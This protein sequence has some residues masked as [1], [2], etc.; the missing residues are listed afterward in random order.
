MPQW[1][2]LDKKLSILIV[3]VFFSSCYYSNDTL[4]TD[5]ES[6]ISTKQVY[7]EEYLKE[8]ESKK[9]FSKDV[10]IDRKEDIG[11]EIVFIEASY[12]RELRTEPAEIEIYWFGGVAPFY[13]PQIIGL[14][15]EAFQK[16]LNEN[17]VHEIFYWIGENIRYFIFLDVEVIFKS[18]QY[19]SLSQIVYNPRGR[20]NADFHT[21]YTTIDMQ[22]GQRVFLDDLIIVNDDLINLFWKGKIVK[23][24][25]EVSFHTGNDLEFVH[26]WI[27]EMSY[28]KIYRILHE[29]SERPPRLPYTGYISNYRATLFLHHSFFL[30]HNRVVIV[31]RRFPPF[32]GFVLSLDDISQFLKVS[33]W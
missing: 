27:S 9:E 16:K 30:E 10:I 33:K 13:I 6:P 5:I 3:L 18:N 1:K 28:E 23:I 29:P 2:A 26:A 25:E 14:E 15:D 8:I 22:T 11:Y 21:M 31:D 19:L 32:A 20:H 24:H 17:I 7:T 12:F 4:I